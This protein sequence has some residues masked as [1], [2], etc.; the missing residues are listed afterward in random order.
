LA[1]LTVTKPAAFSTQEIVLPSLRHRISRGDGSW[2]MWPLPTP[3]DAPPRQSLQRVLAEAGLEVGGAEVVDEAP[4][5]DRSPRDR[6][7]SLELSRE[8]TGLFSQDCVS[9]SLENEIMAATRRKW[10]ARVRAIAR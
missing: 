5:R 7:G 8:L 6:P 10:R 1:N 3:D 4:T 2:E 9:S